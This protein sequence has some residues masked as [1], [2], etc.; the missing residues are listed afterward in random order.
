MNGN[1]AW[2]RRD[3]GK[4][5]GEQRVILIATRAT[6]IFFVVGCLSLL[7]EAQGGPAW[8]GLV[9]GLSFATILLA[10]PLLLVVN[11]DLAVAWMNSLWTMVAWRPAQRRHLQRGSELVQW[12]RWREL[13][14]AERVAVGLI[15]LGCLVFGL[16]VLRYTLGSLSMHNHLAP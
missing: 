16:L 15:A 12:R 1:P 9:G 8:V 4:K 10:P 7:A 3:K 2:T 6:G 14:Y 11:A 13:E 5:T